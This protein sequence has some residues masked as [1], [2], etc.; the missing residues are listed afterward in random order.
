LRRSVGGLLGAI[1]GLSGEGVANPIPA[2]FARVVAGHVNPTTIGK[3]GDVDAFV[4][5]ATAVRGLNAAQISERL[6]IEPSPTGYKVIEFP[7]SKVTGIA[8]PINRANPGF[9]GGG[10]TIGGAPEYVIPNTAIPEGAT[11]TDVPPAIE[12]FE[13]FIDIP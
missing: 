5:D 11:I 1:G 9:V 8:S 10:R 2:T 4:T 13:P 12:P 6:G 3:A 7:S